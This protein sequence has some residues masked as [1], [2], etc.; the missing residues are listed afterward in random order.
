MKRKEFQTSKYLAAFAISLLIFLFGIYIGG[1]N[2]KVKLDSLQDLEDDLR[3]STL[4][5]ELQYE[6]VAEDPCKAIDSELFTDK[7]ADMGSKLTNMESELGKDSY[8]VIKLKEEYSLL[9]IRQYLFLKKAQ[10]ECSNKKDFILYFYS[11][12]GDCSM[13]EEHGFVLIYLFY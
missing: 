6:L 13:C 5:T 10:R 9:E 2:N 1:Y 4:G 11:N 3:I 8:A 7:L 12:A